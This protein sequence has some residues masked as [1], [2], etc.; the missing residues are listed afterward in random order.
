[1]TRRRTIGDN[2][3]DSITEP[4]RPAVKPSPAKPLHPD[5]PLVRTAAPQPETPTKKVS[6]M[7][8]LPQLLHPSVI[9]LRGGD[10]L[11][12]LTRLTGPQPDA[13]RGFR[14]MGG[15][16]I[17]IKRDVVR[18]TVQSAETVRRTDRLLL[19]ATLGAFAV[20]PLGALAGSLYGG[21]ARHSTQFDL[22]LTDGRTVKA[23][24]HPD[25]VA[26][27]QAEIG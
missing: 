20:G 3:L 13:S 10:V 19:W 23:V 21:R 9:Q 2:P 17:E 1:M 16:F 27:I 4:V 25:T 7:P 8:K 12:G 18:L 22:Q 6:W 26:D 24:A 15:E 14:L 5:Q 11:P